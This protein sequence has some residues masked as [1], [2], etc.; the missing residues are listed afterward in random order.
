MLYTAGFAIR[1]EIEDEIASLKAAVLSAK[2]LARQA[3][4]KEK[5]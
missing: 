5:N 1:K 4:V 3:K 2:K